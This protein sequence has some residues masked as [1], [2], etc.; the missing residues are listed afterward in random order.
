MNC[1]NDMSRME[2]MVRLAIAALDTTIE[3]KDIEHLRDNIAAVR[4]RPLPADVVA[5]I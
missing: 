3:P 5:E 2:F 4:K 1:Q